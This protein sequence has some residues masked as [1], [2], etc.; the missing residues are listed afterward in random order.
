MSQQSSFDV[1]E[2]HQFLHVIHDG[3]GAD[4]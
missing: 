1:Q 4:I 3:K 2:D